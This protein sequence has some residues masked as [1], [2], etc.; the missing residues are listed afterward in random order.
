MDN[1]TNV[2]YIHPQKRIISQKKKYSYLTFTGLFFLSIGLISA[3]PIKNIKGLYTIITSPSNLLTDYLALGGFGSVF[4]NVGTLTLLSILLAYR[5]NVNLNGP[6]FASILTVTGFS[7]FGKNLYNSISIILGVYLYARFVHKPFSQYIMVGLFASALSP[8]VSYITFG[9]SLPLL[10]GNFISI[11]GIGATLINMGLVGAMLCVY[12]LLIGGKV[13]GPIVG[14][15]LSVAGFSAFG[16]HLKN[17]FPILVG[18]YLASLFG[19]VYKVNQTTMIVAAIFGTGL[20]P[21]SGFYGS[22]YGVLAGFLHI[23]LVHNVNTLHGGL[24][25]YNS[26]FSTGFVAGI[27]VP[28]LDSLTV[29]RKEKNLF[30]KRIIKKDH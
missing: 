18:I 24:S 19:T 20:A 17:C 5:H 4:I 9:M 15:I 6:M 16:S 28:I 22:I 13:N 26:G 14:A 1:E 3:D 27:L 29:V 7:F 25:L 8:V 11:S 2:I 21:I 23:A 30:G 12:V 10:T